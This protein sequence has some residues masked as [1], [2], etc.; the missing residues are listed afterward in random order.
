MIDMVKFYP[1][2]KEQF[3]FQIEENGIIELKSPFN[4]ETGEILK[5]PKSGRYENLDVR[6]TDSSSF[7]KGSLH[8]FHNQAFYGMQHNHNDFTFC[9]CCNAIETICSKL[10]IMPIETKLTNLEF[11]LN[12]AVPNDPRIII[13]DNVLM[14]D[15]ADHTIHEKFRGKGDY[16]EFKKYDYS[17]KIY[18]KSK[19]YQIDGNILRIEVKIISK[20]KLN[21][22]GIFNLDDIVNKKAHFKLFQFLLDQFDKLMIVD[23]EKMKKTLRKSKND[24]FKDYCNPH[25]WRLLKQDVSDKVYSR[26]KRDFYAYSHAM[27]IDKTKN[28]IRELLKTKFYYLMNCYPS[29]NYQ[30][31]A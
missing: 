22:L 25:Y 23:S 26:N 16:K 21:Q 11:G 4:R 18:N 20:R 1:L 13:E 3:D 17:L 30:K 31:V 9:E 5:F 19:H 8:K 6:F 24:S 28:K 12:I 15:F 2:D 29:T 10:K 7:V 27:G 14:Y